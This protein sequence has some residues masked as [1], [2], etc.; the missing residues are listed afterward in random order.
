MGAHL[1]KD[2]CVRRTHNIS[3]VWTSA[4]CGTVPGSRRGLRVE[5]ACRTGRRIKGPCLAAACVEKHDTCPV[6]DMA[7]TARSMPAA[8][9]PDEPPARR[10]E[11]P[12]TPQDPGAS[13]AA[14]AT[15]TLGAGPNDPLAAEAGP[16]SLLQASP[17]DAALTFLIIP[18]IVVPLRP[19]P[20]HDAMQ[21]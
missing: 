11:P 15:T 20:A 6:R 18:I 9:P 5:T 17:S 19:M 8:P 3:V 21:K 1:W 14:G 10:R 13:S 16:A 4:P 12:P 2:V 7:D